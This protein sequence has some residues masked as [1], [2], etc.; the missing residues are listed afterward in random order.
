MSPKAAETTNAAINTYTTM[1]TMSIS[2]A[3][4]RSKIEANSYSIS[5]FCD[6]VILILVTAKESINS[7]GKIRKRR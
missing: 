4:I 5:I 1:M 6:V 3:R 2:H 7:G